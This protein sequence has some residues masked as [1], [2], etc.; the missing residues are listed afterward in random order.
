MLCTGRRDAFI[1]EKVVYP[2]IGGAIFILLGMLILVWP[3][4]YRKMNGRAIYRVA[5]VFMFLGAFYIV[6]ALFN[7]GIFN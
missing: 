6:I 3:F 7:A 4:N 5:L 2:I 1:M